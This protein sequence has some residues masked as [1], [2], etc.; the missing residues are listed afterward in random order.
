MPLADDMRSLVDAVGGIIWEA[1]A[2]TLRFLFVSRAAE[3]LLGY[4]ASAWL[5]E[6]EFWRCHLHPDDEERS[7]AQRL[8]AARCGEDHEL[9]YR[10][11]AADGRVVWLR[12]VAGVR[13][14]DDGSTT[15]VGIAVDATGRKQDDDARQELAEARK[16]D[17]VGRLAGGVAHDFNNLLTVIAGYAELVEA[18]LEGT[19]LRSGELGEIKRAAHRA[20][21]LTRQLLAF[22]RKQVFRPE[23][24]DMN[25]V[26]RG[27]SLL[28]RR[29]MAEGIEVVVELTGSR[30]PVY[31]DRLQLEQVLLNLAVNA[32][33][34]MPAGGRLI[35]RTEA[36]ESAVF[37]IV[38]DNGSGMTPDVARRAFEP[39]FTTREVGKGTGLGLSTAYG[40]IKQSGG[41]IRVQSELHKGSVFT[42]SLPLAPKRAGV[43]A[44]AID[45]MPGGG[46]AI[47]V[48]EDDPAAREAVEQILLAL[49]YDVLTAADG[50]AAVEL[51]RLRHEKISLL[52][53]DVVMQHET[54]PQVYARVAA[55]MPGI[56]VLFLSG[57][58][59]ESVLA[60]GAREE[61]VAHLQTP[62]TPKALALRV[63]EVL[64]DRERQALTG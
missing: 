38:T 42:I 50:N 32:R 28:V 25:D 24:L 30:L 18:T 45:D 49:G 16:M 21:L 40:I 22:S 20:G 10:M 51:C 9:E 23:L 53:T 34:A 3:R 26:V 35:I 59:G 64:D 54:G 58:T 52:V 15:L 19:D 31:A 1:E 37:V 62:F 47:L 29:M 4:P 13:R 36:T 55:L 17:A 63:R 41:D 60:R 6:A 14:R 56:A 44:P 2:E 11:I 43:K 8:A 46:E 5:E 33:D 61:G 57:Y 27:A 7:V 39:F 12:D 48:V